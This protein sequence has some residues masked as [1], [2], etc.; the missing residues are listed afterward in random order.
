MKA[1]SE[2]KAGDRVR[3][4]LSSARIPMD[5]WCVKIDDSLIHCAARPDETDPDSI[6]TF[7]KVMY[8]EVDERFN[9]GPEHGQTGSWLE[10]VLE[11]EDKAD[12]QMLLEARASK[13]TQWKEELQL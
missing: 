1:M 7:D 3:R 6:W 12:A 11:D 13:E 9:W 10:G 8:V 5:L 2:L 4:L